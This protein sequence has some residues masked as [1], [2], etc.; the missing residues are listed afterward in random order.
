MRDATGLSAVHGS[1]SLLGAA[2]PGVVHIAS[3]C[4][5]NSSCRDV[6]FSVFIILP[7]IHPDTLFYSDKLYLTR[8]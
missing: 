4:S 7:Y 8:V 1:G 3:A 2:C 5:F 6:E